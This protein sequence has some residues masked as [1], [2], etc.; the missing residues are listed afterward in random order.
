MAMFSW[1][2]L[3]RILI[4]RFIYSARLRSKLKGKKY[5]HI[6][7]RNRSPITEGESDHVSR[8]RKEVIITFPIFVRKAFLN[9]QQT[10]TAG[11]PGMSS[12][13]ITW[14][15][16]IFQ[17]MV[18]SFLWAKQKWKFL[19]DPPTRLCRLLARTVLSQFASLAI[20]GEL[21]SRLGKT[22][23]TWPTI[24]WPTLQWQKMDRN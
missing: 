18:L 7:L 21:A 16:D 19:R 24:K 4:Y 20:H 17:P 15:C 22:P 13:K 11:Q 23:I 10:F 6:V 9:V 3:L 14:R 2:P 5:S 8:R 12:I 1:H